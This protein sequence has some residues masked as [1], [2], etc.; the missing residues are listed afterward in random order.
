[1]STN[2]QP[3]SDKDTLNTLKQIRSNLQHYK[4][5]MYELEEKI[6][7]KS[8]TEA[9]AKLQFLYT[10]NIFANLEILSDIIMLNIFSILD[11]EKRLKS[12][13]TRREFDTSR[14]EVA[15]LKGVVKK[16]LEIIKKE[17]EKLKE[18]EKRV[19]DIY[20]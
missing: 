1:M 9:I 15:K 5:T 10:A 12:L 8:K 3:L 7:G 19:S 18:Q 4:R 2:N 13:P 14:V 17:Y 20:G 6:E 16:S 11:I